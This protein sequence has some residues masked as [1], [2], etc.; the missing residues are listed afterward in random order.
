MANLTDEQFAHLK[1]LL[2]ER[3][4]AVR[5]DLRR[6]AGQQEDFIDVATEVPDPGDAS[7][8][9]LSVD[10]GNAAVGRDLTELRGIEAARQR[11]E[12]GTYGDCVNC[13]TEIPYERLL[14]QPAAERCAPCQEMHEK[15]HMNPSRG[16]TM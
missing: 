4:R 6:E 13:E 2:D 8:A 3:D 7:F 9:D 14:V 10:L 15:T 1:K 5:A 11:M 12:S 16:N